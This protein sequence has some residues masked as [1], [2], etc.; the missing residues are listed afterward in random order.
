MIKDFLMLAGVVAAFV[1]GGTILMQAKVLPE[2]HASD[3]R[4]LSSIS[5]QSEIKVIQEPT[6]GDDTYIYAINDVAVQS[7]EVA[8][9]DGRVR[10]ILDTIRGRSVT[11]AAVQ[12]TAFVEPDGRIVHS[13][14]GQVIVTANWQLLDGRPYAAQSFGALAGRQGKSHQMI[15]NIFVDLD[16]RTVT[17]VMEE[18]ERVMQKTLA[19]NVVYG[20]MNMY[21]PFAAEAKA[22]TIVTWV[23][24][25]PVQHNVVGVYKTASGEANVDSGF[26]KAGESWQRTF[27]EE[28]VFEYHCTI[29]SEEGMKGRIVISG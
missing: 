24:D 5:L 14:Q 7:W 10:E 25:S 22:D 23:N 20:G 16:R 13:G 4:T 26:F 21:M 1:A 17:N 9:N 12:P 28:G 2:E 27:E 8:K 3:F 29:H 19:E 15:W 6:P 18:P 11:I